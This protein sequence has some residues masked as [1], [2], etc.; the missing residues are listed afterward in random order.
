MPSDRL[1]DS[2]RHT[3]ARPFRLT[4]LAV[5]AWGFTVG[6]GMYLMSSFE[7]TPG[8]N[9]NVPRSWPVD[10]NLPHTSK[11]A[12]LVF[13]AHPR[14]PCTTASLEQL[15]RVLAES[16]IPVQSDIVFL[17]PPDS[18]SN[19]TDTTN[20]Q[21]ARSLQPSDVIFD[22]SAEIRRFGVTTSG[23]V[24]LYDVTDRLAFSGGV[25][26]SRGQRGD[27]GGVLS[28]IQLLNHQSPAMKEAP[29]FGCPLI[30]EN[31]S[32]GDLASCPRS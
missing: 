12:T 7:N 25:T 26:I 19:W 16:K 29:V 23:H 18:N 3:M 28:L 4:I 5:V 9:D 17:V 11:K 20:V 22:T 27:N 8:R 6:N 31:S 15:K 1:V 13:F 24:L 10:S 30:P 14:C 32:S 2:Q 21:L